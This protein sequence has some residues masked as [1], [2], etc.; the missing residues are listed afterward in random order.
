HRR[1]RP[2]HPRPRR[3]HLAAH[4]PEGPVMADTTTPPNDA[5]RFIDRLNTLDHLPSWAEA[6]RLDVPLIDLSQEELAIRATIADLDEASRNL[7]AATDA[8]LVVAI[9]ADRAHDCAR[10][11]QIETR[12]GRYFLA[13]GETV[14]RD[15][16]TREAHQ[17]GWWYDQRATLIT[18]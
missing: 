13:T 15:D 12:P 5:Q 10:L 7:D 3:P 17:T 16:A 11:E 18:T 14:Q 6:A 1:A 9:D 2:E 8:D 4:P